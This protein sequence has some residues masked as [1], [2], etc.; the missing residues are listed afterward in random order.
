[1]KILCA[2]KEFDFLSV[3]ADF[4]VVLYDQS[5]IATRGS[6]G[7]AVKHE[8][9]QRRLN[10]AP[11]AWDL[12]SLALAAVAADLAGHRDKSPDGWTREFD[13]TV[14]VVDQ[15]WPGWSEQRFGSDR[16]FPCELSPLIA[17]VGRRV[18][19]A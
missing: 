14:A 13:L 18:G 4:A 1:M 15:R 10:P 8:I 16:W 6:V 9:V 5:D 2:P 3:T 11:R 7:A 17:V 19:R 12:L